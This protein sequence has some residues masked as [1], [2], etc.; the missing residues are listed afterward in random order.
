MLLRNLFPLR[1]E[2]FINVGTHFFFTVEAEEDD[3]DVLGEDILDT[4]NGTFATSTNVQSNSGFGRL[5]RVSG[6]SV[7]TLG[8]D[9]GFRVNEGDKVR[10]RVRYESTTAGSHEVSIESVVGQS[11]SDN[12]Q[13]SPTITLE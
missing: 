13:L 8:G 7:T 11:I 12:S 9:T 6:D 1:S 2:D 4:V 3:V 5:T 10:F